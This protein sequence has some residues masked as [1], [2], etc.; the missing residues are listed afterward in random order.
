MRG[1]ISDNLNEA[2]RSNVFP[3]GILVEISNGAGDNLSQD[4]HRKEGISNMLSRLEKE[5][6]LTKT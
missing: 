1:F 4:D 6:S 3:D 2:E 5:W